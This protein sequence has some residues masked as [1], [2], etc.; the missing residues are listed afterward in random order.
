MQENNNEVQDEGV[1]FD[2]A[3]LEAARATHVRGAGKLGSENCC[4]QDSEQEDEAA[5]TRLCVMT[6]QMFDL[7]RAAWRRSGADT[8]PGQ[9][10]LAG[11]PRAQSEQQLDHNALAWAARAS[12]CK[13][14]L[15]SFPGVGQA[16]RDPEAQPLG[17]PVTADALLDWRVRSGLNRKQWELL[18]VVV[19]RVLV[20]LELAPPDH[21]IALRRAEA[22]GLAAARPAGHWEVPRPEVPAGIVRGAAR[23]RAGHRL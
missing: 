15:P 4:E 13:S 18:R 23:L 19:E 7:S 14:R 5:A 20:E 12:R 6:K 9:G 10:A 3:D 21:E 8:S 1:R 22:A 2:K 16:G 11:P 17:P